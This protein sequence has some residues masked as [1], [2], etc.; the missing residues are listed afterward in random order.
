MI[1]HHHD[2]YDGSGP[3]QVIAGSGIPLGA[4]IIATADAFDA[5]TSDRP[6]RSAMSVDE[7]IREI[8]RGARTQFDPTIITAFIKTVGKVTTT[9]TQS[10]KSSALDAHLMD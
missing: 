9:Q 8:Q 6:Y 4:R 3:H 2:R 10:A 1:E 5:M 7:A